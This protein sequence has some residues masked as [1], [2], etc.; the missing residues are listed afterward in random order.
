VVGTARIALVT[1][2]LAVRYAEWLPLKLVPFP[3]TIPPLVEPLQWHKAYSQNPA[4][5]WFR[6]QMKEAVARMEL[7]GAA[8]K[9]R[10]F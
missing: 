10:A 2:R 7:A 4:H 9:R 3:V 6:T 8:E 5:L 1:T